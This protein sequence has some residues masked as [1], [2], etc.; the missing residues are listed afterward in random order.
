M[1]SIA[2]GDLQGCGAQLQQL[3]KLIDTSVVEKKLIFAGDLINRGPQSLQTL[4]AV[5]AMGDRAQAV[6][7]NHD[8]HLLAVSQGIRPLHKDDT[9]HE[10]LDAPD[11]DELI[12][13][14]RRLPL[15]IFH[16]G[17]LVVHA[18]VLPQWDAAQAMALAGEV[19]DM[20][21]SDGWV[22]FLT[23]MYGNQPDRWSD[24][25]QGHDR[26]RCIINAFTRL[27]FCDADGVMDFKVKEGAAGAPEGLM[28]WFDVPGR[29]TADTT[30]VFGHW[31]TLGLMLRP[32]LM[33][34]DTGC[35][36]GGKL[37][38]VRLSDRALFQVDCP[39]AQK[40]G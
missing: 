40:P 25:L 12:D 6:L 39:Q 20:L 9:L 8:L 29:R 1:T 17:H 34:L 10:I 28:P 7:G 23:H 18:G 4:R 36:W 31:S 19:Q 35:V 30:V 11:R 13:W 3:L 15:A 5:M 33:A 38:A 24:E 32:N 26:L 27:R 22:D 37:T 14:L 21:R 2:I 16:E